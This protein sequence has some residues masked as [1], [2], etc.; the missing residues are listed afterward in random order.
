MSESDRRFGNVLKSTKWL[1]LFFVLSL[2]QQRRLRILLE[3]REKEKTIERE[4][5]RLN[6][7]V[8]L[9]VEQI[10]ADR[11][12]A[13]QAGRELQLLLEAREAQLGEQF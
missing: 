11:L 13:E 9:S 3:R 12:K 6:P 5:E 2:A 8:V 4:K 1:Y 7:K 10:E